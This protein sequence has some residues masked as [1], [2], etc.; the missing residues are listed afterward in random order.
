M[1]V[2]VRLA[3]G[4]H[5]NLGVDGLEELGERRGRAVVRH[6]HQLGVDRRVLV[7][8]HLL[9]RLLGLS[10]EQHRV[11]TVVQHDHQ[12]V[13][14]RV[15]VRPR[16]APV[17]RQHVQTEIADREGVPGARVSHRHV[18]VGDRD[19]EIG[20]DRRCV[21]ATR[22]EH[23]TDR[24]SAQHGRQPDDVVGV[25]MR[26]HHDVQALDAQGREVRRDLLLVGPAVD[27]HVHAARRRHERR[28]ALAD[29]E[30]PHD[31]A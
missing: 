28:V 27:E 25:G 11:L 30:E 7:Q 15:G 1:A 19:V 23:Q 20:L 4:D 21:G 17:G 3:H 29:V 26:G 18:L 8:Q 31:Q 12:R 5:R 9:R 16:P 2:V 10:A 22:L 14:V 13:V 24:H 6:L